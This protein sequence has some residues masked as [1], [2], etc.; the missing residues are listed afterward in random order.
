MLEPQG[1]EDGPQDALRHAYWQCRMSKL[2]GE[3]TAKRWGDAHEK[4]AT[5]AAAARMDL[6]NNAAGRAVAREFSSCAEG[7][8]G[9]RAKGLLMPNPY[10][11]PSSPTPPSP[12]PT[13]PAGET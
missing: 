12:P 9:A 7:V 13:P 4:Y 5:Y 1:A 2:L 11:L 6:H 8:L 3:D 10:P